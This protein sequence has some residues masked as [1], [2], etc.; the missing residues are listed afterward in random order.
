MSPVKSCRKISVPSVPETQ[1]ETDS[2][3][4]H[5]HYERKLSAHSLSYRPA[6]VLSFIFAV[7]VE[8]PQNTF[9]HHVEYPDVERL[10]FALLPAMY[11]TET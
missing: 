1:R 3:I 6:A 11:K 9:R 5:R 8:L 4:I 10:T 7:S 2:S